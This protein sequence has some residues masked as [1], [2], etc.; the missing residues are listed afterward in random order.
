ME[1]ATS[2]AVN[3]SARSDSGE[4]V[5][6]ELTATGLETV[7][8][9]LA[10]VLLLL[11]F[12]SSVTSTIMANDPLGATSPAAAE[13]A[14]PVIRQV[15]EFVRYHKPD[16][17]L[18]AVCAALLGV[19]ASDVQFKSLVC[20]WP[21]AMESL[22]R[23]T[24]LETENESLVELTCRVI[25][26]VSRGQSS[27]ISSTAFFGSARSRA[28]LPY[29][30][31]A[32]SLACRALGTFPGSVDTCSAA[33]ALAWSIAYQ[34]RQVQALARSTESPSDGVGGDMFWFL[35]EALN[36]HC[37]EVQL[38]THA[39]VALGNLSAGSR[40]NQDRV[41][42]VGAVEAVVRALRRHMSSS[43]VCFTCCSMLYFALNGHPL[44]GIIFRDNGG[45][46]E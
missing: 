7:T 18:S 16:S 29:A 27:K 33:A 24:M 45:V 28:P 15:A 30:P 23:A 37:G 21:D 42:K 39:C 26:V 13:K 41:G 17:L 31:N 35:T 4:A 11:H 5:V 3:Y 25:A 46:G 12:S 10:T 19:I 6:D 43:S 1:A 9:L 40:E 14:K 22:L 20:T 44:N 34:N 36:M 2:C 8:A 38:V 32:V